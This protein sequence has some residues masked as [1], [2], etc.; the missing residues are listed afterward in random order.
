VRL[1]PVLLCSCG[2]LSGLPAS[3]HAIEGTLTGVHA[4]NF[5][6]GLSETRWRLRAKTGTVRVLPTELPAMA[7]GQTRVTV[8]GSREAGA[9]VG[10]V[11]PASSGPASLAGGRKLAVI[12]FNFAADSRQPWTPATV[13]QRV[14]TGGD[15]TSAFFREESHDG[16]WLTG[17]TGNLDGDVY[18]YY[19]IPASNGACNYTTWAGQAKAAAAAD[20]FVEGLYQHVMYVFPGQSSCRWAG[21]AYLPGTESWINGELTVRVTGHEL[22]HN[23]G[24]NHA[25]SWDC[26][27]GGTPVALSGSC[28]VNEYND[29]FDNMGGHGD[30]HSHGW[31]LERLGFLEPSNVQTISTPG[32][33]SMTSALDPTTQPTT[34]RIPRTRDSGGNPLDWY[35]LEVRERGGVFEDFSAFDPVLSGVSIRVNDDPTQLTRSRLLDTHPASGGIGNAPLAPGE[36][37]SDGQINIKTLS[38]S[39]GDATVQITMSGATLDSQAPSAPS[40]LSHTIGPGGAVRLTWKAS[41]DNVGVTG[42]PVFRD[43]TQIAS[44]GSSSFED[45]I[46]PK[47][48]HVYTIHAED[49]AGNRSPASA[50]H[51]VVVA[52]QGAR[53]AGARKALKADRRG[54]VIRLSRRRTAAGTLMLTARARDRGGVKRLALFVDGRRVRRTSAARLRYAWEAR[55]GSHRVVVRAVDGAGNR[56][57]FEL[58]L[59]LLR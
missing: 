31:H 15:S 54:P 28:T 48:P 21:L 38:A 11:R 26:T 23:L 19:T 59:R 12:V 37:F 36:T 27:S 58:R 25:A 24:L 51:T 52:G 34:L 55:P 40:S 50:P 16:L 18:G 44:A 7:P 14:F 47:G 4:D 30:R 56:S 5:D 41:S 49:G 42:Y 13:R 32:T 39:G 3:A 6:S 29:P 20:G 57:S 22:G 8:A 53:P 10:E 45:T 46:A 9:I 33:Y 43:G 35:Y 1:V 2:F 17:R